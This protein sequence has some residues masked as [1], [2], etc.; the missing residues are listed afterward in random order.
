MAL[1][2]NWQFYTSVEKKLKLKVRKFMGLILTFVEED[3][4]NK[5]DLIHVNRNR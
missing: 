5:K 2:T 4:S 1:G 3:L